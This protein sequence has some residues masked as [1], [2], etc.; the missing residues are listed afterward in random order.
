MVQIQYV[1]ELRTNINLTEWTMNSWKTNQLLSSPDGLL[2]HRS[3]LDL[4]DWYEGVPSLQLAFLNQ[5][6]ARQLIVDYN[7]VQL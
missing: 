6:V 1:F 2:V 3:A 4:V 7:V 5:L